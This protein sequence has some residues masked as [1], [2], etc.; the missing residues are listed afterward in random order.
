[1]FS[2]IFSFNLPNIPYATRCHVNPSLSAYH[3]CDRVHGWCVV[4]SFQ[5]YW[6]ALMGT[7]FTN[8]QHKL[9]WNR[10]VWLK[11]GTR[12]VRSRS[13]QM[14][15]CKSINQ[16]Y[17][18]HIFLGHQKEVFMKVAWTS[19]LEF[20][21]SLVL[22]RNQQCCTKL[23]FTCINRFC[24]SQRIPNLLVVIGGANCPSP[25]WPCLSHVHS[26]SWTGSAVQLVQ[27][28]WWWGVLCMQREKQMDF[29]LSSNLNKLAV[30]RNILLCSWDGQTTL[31]L[32]FSLGFQDSIATACAVSL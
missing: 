17:I 29:L 10:W 16:L 13:N 12:K 4:A 14:H 27:G 25:A 5:H 30:H 18:G 6:S 11:E 1:M 28:S 31:W 9:P 22:W 15:T 26:I 23:E 3:L 24:C 8:L 21:Y 32:T 19:Y 7:P 2:H 20:T